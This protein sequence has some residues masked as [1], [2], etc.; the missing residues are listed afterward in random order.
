MSTK[1][2]KPA[3]AAS[4]PR[5][6]P[7]PAPSD[8]TKRRSPSPAPAPEAGSAWRFL[9]GPD[10]NVYTINLDIL[11]QR[12][13]ACYVCKILRGDGAAGKSSDTPLFVSVP[14]WYLKV[15]RDYSQVFSPAWIDWPTHK[16]SKETIVD[17]LFALSWDPSG[18]DLP[19]NDKGIRSALMDLFKSPGQVVAERKK[20]G[21]LAELQNAVLGFREFF[22]YTLRPIVG[23]DSMPTSS[24]RLV[25]PGPDEVSA[26]S[27]DAARVSSIFR[28]IRQLGT[29]LVLRASVFNTWH[30]KFVELLISFKIED[31]PTCSAIVV[32]VVGLWTEPE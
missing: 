27:A 19:I 20:E 7:G 2:T 1:R 24:K 14:P 8:S 26:Q 5:A 30:E 32:S 13:P 31:P 18:G 16:C 28:I 29:D 3:A 12:A 23:P 4:A 25:C 11:Q 21:S 17:V 22:V 6:E 10:G 9:Q 15:V